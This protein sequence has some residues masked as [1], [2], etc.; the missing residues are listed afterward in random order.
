[1]KWDVKVKQKLQNIVNDDY[2]DIPAWIINHLLF[3][4]N[5]AIAY[6]RRINFEQLEEIG[7][8]VSNYTNGVLELEDFNETLFKKNYGGEIDEQYIDRLG[9]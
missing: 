5:C 1:M 9:L 4:K 3:Y 7:L 6:D 8:L 2:K